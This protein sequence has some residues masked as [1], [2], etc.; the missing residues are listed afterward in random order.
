MGCE[1]DSDYAGSYADAVEQG[2][3]R[4]C[5]AHPNESWAIVGRLDQAGLE[6]TVSENHVQRRRVIGRVLDMADAIRVAL[7]E[8]RTS[9]CSLDG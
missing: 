5:D 7:E 3:Q 9:G 1:I 2:A 4:F 6:L 8:M